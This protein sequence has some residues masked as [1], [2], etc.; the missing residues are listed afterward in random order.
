MWYSKTLWIACFHLDIIDR[1]WIARDWHRDHRGGSV[2]SDTA[3]H[4][5]W[6]WHNG[7]SREHCG[8]GTGCYVLYRSP[9]MPGGSRAH[10]PWTRQRH[11]VEKPC[12]TCFR[13][14]QSSMTHNWRC[15]VL[16]IAPSNY[17]LP[18]GCAGR[19]TVLCCP[20]SSVC[21][22]HFA[23]CHYYN[24]VLTMVFI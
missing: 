3:L 9:G 24:A 18:T 13:W 15:G 6:L 22:H 16:P 4:T 2:C 11:F 21:D 23:S 5:N 8:P 10:F 12:I 17:A 7:R 14:T 1:T 19:Q 20:S